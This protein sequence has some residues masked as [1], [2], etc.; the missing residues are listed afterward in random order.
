MAIAAALDDV[1][2][3]RPAKVIA[4]D[5]TTNT[6]TVQPGTK[7]ALYKQDGERVYEDLPQI[8]GVPVVFQRAGGMVARVP[9][10]PGDT[11]L[12]VFSDTSLAEWRDGE[13]SAEPVD[14][15]EH[16]I[17]WPVA[18]PGLF[19][20]TK[21]PSP[22]DA[23][24]VTAGAMIV[25]EDGGAAQAIFGGT[26]PGIRFG[27]QAVSPIALS[28]PTDAAFSTLAT[29]LNATITKLNALITAYNAHTHPVPGVTT[30]PGATTSSPTAS[31]AT[32]ADAATSPATTAS[33]L[34]KSL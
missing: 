3:A 34:V 20:D 23:A 24:E 30:G 33:A 9:V 18:I 4:Y 6:A 28:V 7:R 21:P 13:G 8:P 26:V 29:A 25:G 17:G 32:A 11:V 1:F 31:T 22:S 5:P 10:Q 27:K 15:R 16:S 19:Q 2:V 14:A 12:L